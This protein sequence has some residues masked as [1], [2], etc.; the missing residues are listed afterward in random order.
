MALE[1]VIVY[2]TINHFC[3]SLKYFSAALFFLLSMQASAFNVT[4]RLQ[5]TGV[6][7]FTT[8][9]VNGTFNG[10][11]GACNPLSDA[12]GNGVWE[13][14]I[15]LPAGYFE[16]K[17]AADNWAQQETL[18]VGAVCT[19]TTGPYTNR[20]LSITSD[21]VLPV[22]CW[23]SCSSCS[24]FN[25]TFQVNMAAVAGYSTPY[26]SGSFNNWCGN[27]NAMSDPDGDQIFTATLPLFSGFY[28]YKF[29]YDNW[30]GSE[31][32]LPGSSCTVTNYGYTNRFVT[33]TQ[34]QTQ[35]LVCWASCEGPTASGSPTPQVQIALT[36][37]SNP[38]CE[39][40]ELVFTASATN[41][42]STPIYQWRVNGSPV[43]GNSNTLTTHGILNGQA[44]TCQLLGGAGCGSTD[45]AVSNAITILRE[46]PVTPSVS[47]TASSNFPVCSNQ[48]IAFTATPIN[49]GN[50]PAYQWKV[51]GINVGTNSST[52]NPTSLLQGQVVTCQ[53]TSNAACHAAPWN[54]IWNDEF[55][56]ASLDATK[57]FP[58]T[59][60]SGWGN[61]EWQ[62]YTGTSN[63]VQ[64]SDGQLHIVARND[65]PP[66]LQYSSARLITK[67]RFSFKYGRVSGRLQIPLGQGIWPAFWMLGANFDQVSWPSCGEIDIMEH[68]NNENKIYGTTHWN[69]GGLNSN[70][71]SIVTG[72]T[73][74]HEYTVEWDSLSIRFF[75][76]GALYHTHNS[77]VSNGSLD[78]FSKPFFLLLNVAIGGNWPGYPNATTV[79]PVSM[80]VD[81]VR[82]WQRNGA[83]TSSPVTSNSIVASIVQPTVWFVDSDGD[84]YG[85][86]TA[87]IASCAQPVGYVANN[88]DCNDALA[89]INP[90]AS[91]NCT[92]NFDDNCNA[93][94]NEGCCTSPPSAPAAITGPFGVC[95]NSTGNVFTTPAVSGATSYQ[96]TLPTGATGSSTTNSITLSFGS[97]YNT[98]NLSVRAVGPCGTSTAF[99]RSVVAFTAV[100]AAPASISGPSAGVCANSTQT[101]TCASVAAAASYQWT[102]PTNATIVSGQG[103]QTVTVSF[104]SN[105]GANGTLSVR[106]QNCFGLS[107]TRTLVVYNIPAT[108][109]AISGTATNVCSGAVLSYSI[110]AVPGA[111]SYLW[112]APANTTISSGQGTTSIS[113]TI[114]A[115]FTGGSLAVRAVS[116]CGQSAQRTF[117]LSRNPSAPAAIVGQTSNLCGGGQYTYSIPAVS[118]ATSY[119]WTVPAGCTIVTNNGTSIVMNVPSTFTTGTLTVQA[120]NLCGGSAARNASLTRLPATP[121]SITGPASVC[122]NQVGVNFTTPAVTGVTQ[123]WTV[124]TGVTITAGQN[125]TS[126]TCTW[127]TAAGSVTLRSVNACGQS[128]ALSRAVTLLTCM[129]EEGGLP[130]ESRLEALEVYPNPNDGAF[131]VRSASSGMYRIISST[132]QTVFEMN[133]NESNNFSFEVGGLSTG[134]YFLVGGSD[135]HY[136]QQKVVVT[137]R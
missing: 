42:T 134:I 128:A 45:G 95:R 48:S 137:N 46:S 34:N 29:S 122:P 129:E 82:V 103:T 131:T 39:G 100:P 33:V 69:N 104:A 85:S 20:T 121:A 47:I 10:W 31:S 94:V 12:D 90:A 105:F 70:S 115:S 68:I 102:A 112:T 2:L 135:G 11:C 86:N 114:G 32:L 111:T 35:P 110:A 109:G 96:W 98:G 74:F 19:A 22:V 9:E 58:E 93:Q 101:Y 83:A 89:A 127:G 123:L 17:F 26:V 8:P 118:G 37:G 125:T 25:V 3:M 21:I 71:G 84:G 136:V 106:S 92:T 132:G 6:N 76:D 38:S 40:T 75:M 130:T 73:G 72:V 66:G 14:T 65:G 61:N 117:S 15:Q 60:A 43:G 4:F 52:F 23:G 55:N 77:S 13:T 49:G 7:G 79:F 126:M 18:P 64:F 87:T 91:E 44:V 113:L 54:M 36:S 119:V 57:W 99:T 59:G 124:P 67:N 1:A 133:L 27:C 80:D 107:N 88:T 51:D 28:E 53:M 97:T 62:N 30:A 81:F 16:Y 41:L 24:N 120:V 56:G 5:M 63:N 108:P 78:E 50:S 116:S